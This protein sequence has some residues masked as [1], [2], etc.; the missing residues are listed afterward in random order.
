MEDIL[1]RLPIP[2]II[3]EGTL[4]AIR[5]LEAL[6]ADP[7]RK[8]GV[9]AKCGDHY[10][11]VEIS[12]ERRAEE[13]TRLEGLLQIINEVCRVEGGA[14]LASLDRGMRDKLVAIAGRPADES[15]QL[16]ASAGRILWTDDLRLG[17][18]ARTVPKATRVW[19]QV[20]AIWATDRG[21]CPPDQVAASTLQLLGTGYFW[22][23]IWPGVVT[24]AAAKSQWDPRQMP[25]ADT[26]RHFG[27]S[28]AEI[29]SVLHLTVGSFLDILRKAPSGKAGY[30]MSCILDQLG[31]RE[32]GGLC[33][34]T[35]LHAVRGPKE[36]HDPGQ[37]AQKI[38]VVVATWFENCRKSGI[39]IH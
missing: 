39:R 29:A 17:D 30:L 8:G 18:L 16:A 11:Y 4:Q 32:G 7:D 1:R 2:L 9:L 15:R 21:H 34:E 37:I 31:T 36:R 10:Q 19:T 6:H 24:F 25:L 20:I 33:A 3:S 38:E 14:I 26:I 12:P 27:D 13:R 35:I 28:N 22:T 23:R 5:D